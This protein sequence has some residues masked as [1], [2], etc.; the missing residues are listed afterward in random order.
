ML[1]HASQMKNLKF[2]IENEGV[3]SA[4]LSIIREADTTIFNL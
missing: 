3:P 4:R 1:R 2:K